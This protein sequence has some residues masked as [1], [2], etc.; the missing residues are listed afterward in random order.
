M[1][2]RV[3]P[4]QPSKHGQL[5]FQASHD[6]S[7]TKSMQTV[8]LAFTELPEASKYYPI[9][10][11]DTETP[12]PAAL[13]SLQKDS[14]QYL[15][16]DGRWAAPYIPAHIRRY[17]FVLQAREQEDD[18]LVSI[19]V[20]APHFGEVEGTPL[21]DAEDK[22][23]ALVEEAIKFLEILQRDMRATREMMN[24][25]KDFDILGIRN[26]E[27]KQGDV[28]DIIAACLVVDAEKLDKLDQEKFME[29]RSKRILPMLYAAQFSQTN[30]RMLSANEADTETN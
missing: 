26:I 25:V 5:K 23:T 3:Q 12:F 30:F 1:F 13:L 14:N 7:F 4:L 18:F 28:S 16:P 21:F 9:I 19:D 2:G 10:F 20:A 15:R 22:P 29:L 6:L 8:P 17:P 27:R 11:G 24:I